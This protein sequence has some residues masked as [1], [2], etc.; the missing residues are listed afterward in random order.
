VIRRVY[1]AALERHVM[2]YA[3]E[4]SSLTIGNYSP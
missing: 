2:K 4:P 1:H 3:A